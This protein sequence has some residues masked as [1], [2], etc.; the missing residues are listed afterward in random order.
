MFFYVSVLGA[1]D[2]LFNARFTLRAVYRV[3]RITDQIRER[4]I[5]HVSNVVLHG[6]AD[7]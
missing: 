2:L 3:A 4:Y 1:C 5:A 6:I 7:R